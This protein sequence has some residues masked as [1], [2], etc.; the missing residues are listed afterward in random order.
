VAGLNPSRRFD[1]ARAGPGIL[2]GQGCIPKA[3][4]SARLATD[5]A[6][7]TGWSIRWRA[8]RRQG[9]DV[10]LSQ[11]RELFEDLI[12][13]PATRRRDRREVSS[14]KPALFA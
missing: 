5:H 13:W 3:R 11:V 1:A 7:T 6:T 12:R 8:N 14:E 10:G 4:V 9:E 2:A